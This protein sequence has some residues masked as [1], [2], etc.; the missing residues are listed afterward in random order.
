MAEEDDKK[1]HDHGIPIVIDDKH[2]TAPKEVMT[3]EEL[4]QLAKPPIGP[5]RDL[6]EVVPGN[7][8]DIKVANDQKVHLKPGMHFYSAPATINP[9]DGSGLPE[10]DEKYLNEK[11]YRW[12]VKPGGLLVLE[13]LAVSA[14][15][16]DRSAVDLMIRVP[17]TYPMAALDMFYVAPELKL[18]S[19]GYP[20]QAEVFEEHGG[21]RWQRFSRHL[22]DRWKVGVDSVKSFLALILAELQS[23]R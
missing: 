5:D 21:R 13:G 6:F 15:K 19:G 23:K 22:Q 11:G 18:K 3:G 4:R 14:D 12:S 10:Q 9:G 16:Y 20:N 17:P 1:H 2:Y 7:H 8:D